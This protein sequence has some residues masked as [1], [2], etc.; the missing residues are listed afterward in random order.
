MLYV[1]DKYML[2]TVKTKCIELLRSTATTSDAV[3][4]LSTANEFHLD[5]LQKESLQYIEDNTGTCLLSS[6]AIELNNDCVQL[7]L[8]SE[9]LS[10]SE[11]EVCIFFLKWIETQ[12]T[13][14]GK[15]MNTENMRG[16]AEEL[17]RFIRFPLVEKA[18]FSNEVSHSKLLTKDEIINV[19]RY[20]HGEKRLLFSDKPRYP[21]IPNKNGQTLC[22]YRHATCNYTVQ[23]CL[24]HALKFHLNR[25][26]W[27]K[28]CIIFGPA[29]TLNSYGRYQADNESIVSRN[30]TVGD[31]YSEVEAISIVESTDVSDNEEE[32]R[33]IVESTDDSDNEEDSKFTFELTDDSDNVVC[34]EI[35]NITSG[36]SFNNTVALTFKKPILLKAEKQYTISVRDIKPQTYL[37]ID[38]KSV[39]IQDSVTITFQNSPKSTAS[40]NVTQGQIAGIMYSI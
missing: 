28:G 32:G 33:S 19:Y 3:V 37:G 7:I 2:T 14:Q 39:C 12:C 16:I 23:S 17:M 29:E 30:E 9:H 22:I 27:L 18:Y 40:T 31:Y 20:H 35:L 26:I 34:W 8:M 25:S 5:D 6:Y 36:T 15:E 24:P 21:R 13:M 10:C 11:T 1:A 4:T 38:C